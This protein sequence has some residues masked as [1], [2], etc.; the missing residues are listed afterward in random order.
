MIGSGIE[1][2]RAFPSFG[3]KLPQ[4]DLIDVPGWMGFG[5]WLG[6]ALQLHFTFMWL[7]TAVGVAYVLYQFVSGNYR[8]VL[9]NRTDFRGVWPMFRHYF[10]F[11]SK[12]TLRETYNPLQKLG[13]TAVV[14]CG[15]MSVITGV[16]LYK[17]VQLAWLVSLLG[18]FQMARLEHFIAMIGFVAFIPGHLAMVAIHGWS[19]FASMFTGWKRRTGDIGR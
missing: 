16:A 13:Y 12:P 6:G 8:Q 5:D 4:H 3:S 9:P 15:V 19:N 17:P 7:F 10:L 2:F 14:L 18:G 1:I 11:G